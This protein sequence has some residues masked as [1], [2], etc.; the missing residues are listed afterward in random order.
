MKAKIKYL[1]VLMVLATLGVIIFQISWLKQ[2]Y[3][4]GREKIMLHA[5][6]MLDETI[7]THKTLTA[8]K[9]K[10]LL[11]EIINPKTDFETKVLY[12]YPDSLNVSLGYKPKRTY[13]AAYVSFKVTVNQLKQIEADP[14]QFLQEE[15][16]AANLDELSPIYSSII[17]GNYYASNTKEDQLQTSLMKCFNYLYDD[18]AALNR[19][20]NKRLKNINPNFNGTIVHFNRIDEVLK[21]RKL[22]TKTHLRGDDKVVEMVMAPQRKS[23]LTTKIDS[24]NV[25]VDSLNLKGDSVYAV[26]PVLDDLN[27]ILMNKVPVLM[28]RLKVP[29]LYLIHQMIY[30]LVSSVLLLLLISFC[31]IYMLNLIL[32]QKKLADIKDDFISNVSHELKTPVSTALAAV[33]GLQ[34]FEV[35]KD[36][37]KTH[38]YLDTASKELKRL[39]SMIDI[40][41]KSAIFES[42]NFK[43]QITSFNLK[44]MLMEWSEIQQLRS[45]KS[46]SIHINFDG[47]TTIIADQAHLCNVINNLA[48][49]AIKYGPDKV[50]IS[51]DCTWTN[52]GLKMRFGDNG[53]GIPAMHQKNI[54]DKFFRVPTPHDHSIKGYG[55]GLSYVKNII[56]KHG[57]TINLIKSDPTGTVFEINLPQ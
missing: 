23:T 43:L 36:E 25:Y 17:G 38:Q 2:S 41:L 14:Y 1:V 56:E 19:I 11:L 28:L 40:M 24:M 29:T 16:N 6:R 47:Q 51:I 9:V 21:I 8:V 15:I 22:N 20:F 26:K 30:S 46:L 32:K 34:Y 12:R 57:G 53:K 50:E 27:N 48:D 35:L 49:N 3:Q 54:F 37:N 31:L 42:G 45:S 55:L 18:T 52:S 39:S 5:D 4:I 10:K 44:E 13:N 7:V 33:Q